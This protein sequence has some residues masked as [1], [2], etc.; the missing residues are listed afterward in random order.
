M[1]ILILGNGFDL[2]HGLPT[3]YTDFLDYCLSYDLNKPIT[4]DDVLADEFYTLIG[5]SEQSEQKNSWLDYLT[6]QRDNNQ[7]Q[8]ENWIDCETEIYKIIRKL[9]KE[10]QTADNLGDGNSRISGINRI[11]QQKPFGRFIRYDNDSNK[12]IYD[13]D[14]WYSELRRFTRAFEIYCCSYINESCGIKKLYKL[15]E[16]LFKTA[17]NN[18]D[19]N[20]SVYVLNFNYTRT[21]SRFYDANTK[22]I[23]YNF[24]FI[25]GEA[26]NETSL[27]EGI[28]INGLVLGT[29]SFDRL[30]DGKDIP[31]EFNIFQKHNQQHRYGTLADYQRLLLKLRACNEN[32]NIYV[33]GHSL[34]QSDHAKLKHIFCE[35]KNASITIFYHDELSFQKYI[36]NITAILGESDVAVR[37]N[38]KYQHDNALGLLLPFKV[39]EDGRT[40]FDIIDETETVLGE[41]IKD[42]FI[43]NPPNETE[44][45]SSIPIIESVRVD[46][47]SEIS[48]HNDNII[49]ATGNG[50]IVTKSQPCD[51]DNDRNRVAQSETLS[52]MFEIELNVIFNESKYSLREFKYKLNSKQQN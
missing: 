23:D 21:F 1:N 40:N 7:L 52:F 24:I 37:V 2:A 22:G 17:Q 34:D 31:I 25:H 16:T 33:L 50:Y 3:Q 15:N 32:V 39:F 20:N 27:V 29:H 45:S 5:F 11:S 12:L 8:G 35:N 28:E 51:A 42:Y 38:F 41:I 14:T 19:E 30:G 43:D 6:K 36:D 13:V 46:K 44:N 4:P 9:C 10:S 48:L 18:D 49:L 47:V 26:D